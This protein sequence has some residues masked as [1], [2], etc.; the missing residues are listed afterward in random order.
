[1]SEERGWKGKGGGKY[2]YIGGRHGQN[3][4]IFTNVVREYK[5]NFPSQPIARVLHAACNVAILMKTY[6]GFVFLGM[7]RRVLF[8][9]A[10]GLG[11]IG[12][13]SSILILCHINK[14]VIFT[15][16]YR[17]L[18]LYIYNYDLIFLKSVI[19]LENAENQTES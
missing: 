19:A 15:F 2:P 5:A 13:C 14:I 4:D 1:M 3:R 16:R 18:H 11:V 7:F 9:V 10:L 12:I 8:I 17:Y 6:S